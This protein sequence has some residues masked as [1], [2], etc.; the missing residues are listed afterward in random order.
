[1]KVKK[2]VASSMPEAL[3][4]VRNELGTDA[5]ILSSKAVYTGGFLGLFKKRNI[6]VLIYGVVND[7]RNLTYIIDDYKLK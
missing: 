2:Y 6:D 4:K 1:M 5:V 7:N 3:D